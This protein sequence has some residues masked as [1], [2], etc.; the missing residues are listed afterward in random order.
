MSR[1]DETR[2]ILIVDDEER[3][4]RALERSLGQEGW[5]T[6]AASSGEEALG[7]LKRKDVDLVITDLVMPGMDGM[8]LVR[9]IKGFQPGTEV[10]ILTTY[11]SPESM[12]EAETLGVGC[13][14]TKPFDLAYLKSRVSELLGA[15][16][17]SAASSNEAVLWVGPRAL[18]VICSAGGKTVAVA[19]ALPRQALQYIKPRKVM[20][21]AGKFVGTV[22]GLRFSVSGLASVFKKAR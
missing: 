15:L 19:V 22:S 1:S 20:L 2:T 16:K 6:Q 13:Y 9:N 11:G 8:S 12:E 5:Q 18:G 10:M 17:A 14:L 4:R 3:L 7:I 21:A